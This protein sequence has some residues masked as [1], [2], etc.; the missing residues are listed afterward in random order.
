MYD[1]ASYAFDATWSNLVYSM[2]CGGY[3]CIPSDEA[4]RDNITGSM[5]AM[6]VTYI[7]LTP[8][9]ARLL[10]PS[11]V[12][13]L[14]KLILAGEP[15]VH[16]D[17]ATWSSQ[18]TMYNIYGPAEC[19]PSATAVMINPQ[20]RYGGSIGRGL[21]LVTWVICRDGRQLAPIGAVGELWLEGPL[22]GQGYLN[23][24]EK[25]AAAFIEDPP[26][27]LRGVSGYRGRRGR[28]YRTGDLVRYNADGTLVF[29][30]RKDEQVKIRG[31]RVELGEIE[32]HLRY[33]LTA[34]TK[35]ESSHAVAEVVTPADSHSSM[36]VASLPAQC[37]MLARPK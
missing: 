24:L 12:P 2:T 31:Q 25:T 30:G 10:D 1:F 26:W 14:T 19:T 15:M 11:A 13:S 8:S 29:I 21:G 18:V 32:H 35:E 7:D 16:E 36:L 6:K 34:T 28:L 33:I 3:L 37:R 22:V 5:K 20:V 17:V 9:V 4:R 27:L 23:D